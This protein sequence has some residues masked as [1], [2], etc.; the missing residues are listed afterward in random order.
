MNSIELN[1][2]PPSGFTDRQQQA[3][4]SQRMA[5]ALAMGDPRF[6][7][8]NLDRAGFSRGGAQRNQA[9]INAAQAMAEGIS[10]AYQGAM[11]DQK[12]NANLTLQNQQTQERQAQ[13]LASLQQQE[14]YAQQ[15]A[16]LQ[17]QQA[18]MNL[19]GSLLGGLTD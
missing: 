11:D 1:Q 8:K 19:A 9:G 13:A 15:M 3:A 14:A 7:M 12:Y 18:I 17:R 16:R 5:Q 2:V 4:Y 10:E 6:Q